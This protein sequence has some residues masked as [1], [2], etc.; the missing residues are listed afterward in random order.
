[1]SDDIPEPDRLSGAPHPREAPVLF[2]HADAEAAFLEAFNSGRMHH[3]WLLT[4]P[5][6][7]GKATFAWRLARFLLSQ[8]ANTSDGLFG[9]PEPPTH[10]DVDPE[11]PVAR[12]LAALSEP[13]FHLLRR[14]Y[15]PKTKKLKQD[16]TVDAT[17]KLKGFFGLSAA[18]GGRRVVLVDAADELNQNSANAILKLLEEPPEDATLLLV[19]HQ[20]AR[21]LPTIRSRCRTLRLR[22]LSGADLTSAL[23][24]AGAE[25]VEG[26]TAPGLATLADGSVGAAWTLIEQDGLAFYGALVQLLARAPGIDRPAAL[27]LAQTTADLFESRLALI[28]VFLS[29]LARAG[30]QGPPATEAAPG[31][32]ALL[33]RLAPDVAAARRW[34]TLQQTQGDRARQGAAVNLDPSAL[35]LDTLLAIDAT[36]NSPAPVG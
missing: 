31:E 9:A 23:A 11:H 19:T 7:V 10:L 15:D 30:V 12:R 14:P 27:A 21:L 16:I 36:A 35:L 26:P 17:R 32:A 1:M 2:G 25:A 28:D 3:A 20:P 4:G 29:R 13:R 8:P 34:A 33:A 18:D 5:R 6:G 24:Q 22:P